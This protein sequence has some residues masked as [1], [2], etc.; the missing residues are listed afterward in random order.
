MRLTGHIATPVTTPSPPVGEGFAS[1]QRDLG[2]VRG[3][4]AGVLP[5]SPLTR[6]RFAKTPFPARGEGKRPLILRHQPT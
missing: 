2:W 3:T 6:L 4:T 5:R 1:S